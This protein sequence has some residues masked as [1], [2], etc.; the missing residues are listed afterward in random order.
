MLLLFE[1]CGTTDKGGLAVEGSK[2]D[3]E[4]LYL[5]DLVHVLV[6]KPC[7]KWMSFTFHHGAFYYVWDMRGTK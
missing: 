4:T 3:S 2:E 5:G 1:V 7:K 6:E